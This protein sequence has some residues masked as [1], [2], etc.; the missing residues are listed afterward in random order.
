[1]TLTFE[2]LS[3]MAMELPGVEVGTAFGAPTY[4]VGRKS[5]FY[6]NGDHGCP[7]FKVDFDERDFLIEADPE[8]FFTTDHHRNWPCVL[9]RPDRVDI[10]WVRR[11]LERV[12]RA[13]APKTLRK[14]HDEG[15][16]Q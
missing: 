3:R 2:R 7:V 12:W 1:M 5:L 11:N 4:K 13:Q 14:A 9:A 6:W 15:V 16:K 8:T 10:D